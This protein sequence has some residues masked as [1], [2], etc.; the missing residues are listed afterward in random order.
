MCQLFVKEG[1]NV[2]VADTAAASEISNIVSTLPRKNSSTEHIPLSVDVR[3]HQ[4]ISD[5]LK[6]ARASLHAPTVVVNTAR[7]AI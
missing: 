1:A 4:Q 6:A 3:S 5:A 7:I 2:V